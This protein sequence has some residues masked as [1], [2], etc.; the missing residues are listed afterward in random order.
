MSM[1]TETGLYLLVVQSHK[2]EAKAKIFNLPYVRC[3]IRVVAN[4][5][6]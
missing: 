2:P 1:V 6:H 4:S 3:H 5:R